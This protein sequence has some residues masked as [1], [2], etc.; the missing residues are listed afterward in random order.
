MRKL[1]LSL[2]VVFVLLGSGIAGAGSFL[3]MGKFM[4]GVDYDKVEQ[5]KQMLEKMKGEGVDLANNAEYADM[6]KKVESIPPKSTVMLTKALAILAILLA[7]GM[8]VT[9][10]KKQDIATK[11]AIALAVVSAILFVVTP[12]LKGGM[13]APMPL[14]TLIGVAVGMLLLSAASAVGAMK[15]STN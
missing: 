3:T 1:F 12:D 6:I 14:K 11:I 8:C 15:K 9:T 4:K 13:S 10:F 7:L 5:T 2:M